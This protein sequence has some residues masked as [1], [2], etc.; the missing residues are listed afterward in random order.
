M[1]KI[2]RIHPEL[3]PKDIPENE[4]SSK[5]SQGVPEGDNVISLKKARRVFGRKQIP[6]E[7]QKRT[8][9]H[10]DHDYFVSRYT[11]EVKDKPRWC[12]WGKNSVG[13]MAV[14]FWIKPVQND[15]AVAK[16]LA[17]IIVEFN[18]GKGGV[19]AE[20]TEWNETLEGEPIYAR[21]K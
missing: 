16:R 12:V 14:L 1:G 17:E 21:A 11:C 19:R 20:K 18:K 2:E 5:D 7:K 13:D 6:Q 15:E 3:N 9:L 8:A 4:V 10:E